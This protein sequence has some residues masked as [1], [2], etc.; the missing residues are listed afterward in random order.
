MI[1]VAYKFRLYPNKKQ[2]EYFSKCFGC[3][4]KLYNMMLEDREIHYNSTGEFLKISS[5]TEYTSRFSYFSGVDA[6]SL[7]N[8]KRTLDEAYKRFFK[9]LSNHPNFKSKDGK[10][11]YTTYNINGN[12]RL[13]KNDAY[14]KVPKIGL[15]KVRVHR[16]VLGIIK[17]ITISRDPDRKYYISI[18]TE[19][20]TNPYNA[21]YS[22]KSIGLDLGIRSLYTDSNGLKMPN[23]RYLKQSLK[24]IKKLQRKLSR[25]Q[26]KSKNR[27]KARL[28]LAK[29]YSKVSNQRKDYLHKVSKQLINDNQVICLES[30]SVKD[31]CKTKNPNFNRSSQDAGLGMFISML[32]YK[33][34]LYGRTIRTVPKYFPSSQICS[35]CESLHPEMKDL[36][37]KELICSCGNHINRDHNAAINILKNAK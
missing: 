24:K 2:E 25:K 6:S 22:N 32:V 16:K 18:C 35:S 21:P 28:K 23:P 37:N 5:Y 1:N 14:I 15:V 12:I 10:N 9:G 4:R 3:N 13:E 27:E 26:K 19:N 11:S 29:A 20:N 34:K 33:A 36:G 30:L 17:H 31:M 7:S 8:T